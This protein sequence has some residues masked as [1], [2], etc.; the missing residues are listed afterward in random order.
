M[1]KNFLLTLTVIVSCVFN[2]ASQDYETILENIRTDILSNN[3]TSE[4]DIAVASLLLTIQDDGSWTDINYS[5]TANTKWQPLEHLFRINQLS[6]AYIDS[7]STYHQDLNLF[8]VIENALTYWDTSDPQSNNWW[9]NQ[10]ASPRELG[11]V[12]VL[13]RAGSSSISNSLESNLISQMSRGNPEARK[14]A[15]KVDIATHFIYRA[16]LTQN[17]T[18]MNRGVT[19]VFLPIEITNTDEGLQHDYSYRD[20]GPQQAIASYGTVFLSGEVNAA[21]YLLG[22]S[23]ALSQAK[24]DI[25]TQYTLKTI[26]NITRGQHI[27]HSTVGRGISRENTTLGYRLITTLTKLKALDPTNEPQYS[28]EINRLNGS[29]APN[30]MVNEAHTQYWRSDFAVHNRAGYNFSV[31]TSST[32]VKKTEFGNGENRKG[33]Y[34]ADGGSYITIDGDEYYNIYPIW[35]WAKVP[36]ITVPEIT[37]VPQPALW[38]KLGTSTFSGGVSDGLYGIKAHIQNEY[39]TPAKKG[40]FFFDDEV[41]CLGS[42]ISSSATQTIT[43][44]INQCLLDGDV[45]VQNN[46]STTIL[47]PNSNLTYNSTSEWILH[48]NIGYFFPQGGQVKLS[49]HTQSGTWQSINTGESSNTVSKSVFKL[50]IDHGTQPS[51]GSYAYI[52]APNKTSVSQMQAYNTNNNILIT[53]NNN[54]V[55]AVK[56]TGLDMLQIIFYEAGSYD[57]GTTK[58]EVDQPCTLLLKNVSTSSITVHIADPSQQKSSIN[59]FIDI[60]NVTDTRHISNTMPTGVYAGS[61]IVHT[62]DINTPI[63]TVTEEEPLTIITPI[64]DAYVNSGT[65]KNINY[66]DNVGLIVKKDKANTT[67]QSYL[68]F[69]LSSITNSNI[70]SAKL[71]LSI[72]NTNTGVTATSWDA[73]YVNDDSWTEMGITWNNKPLPS[74]LLD[75]QLAVSS[76]YIEWNITPQVLSEMDDDGILSLNISSTVAGSKTDARFWS[77]EY[78]VEAEKP[79]LIIEY[80][81]EEDNTTLKQKKST[82]NNFSI[83]PNPTTSVLNITGFSPIKSIKIL[84]LH[85]KVLQK[86]KPNGVSTNL[87][88]SHYPNGI[89]IISVIDNMDK[90]ITKKIIKQ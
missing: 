80:T 7:G 70:A 20:H 87:N 37:N 48:N 39:N 44:T 86:V 63:K 32:R 42:D 60:P 59:I 11:K 22:T 31:R 82:S 71:R 45:T 40:W 19:Q 16:A 52:V 51:N 64:A 72:A 75:N 81:D 55:Q 90:I 56:H 35:D 36:G 57:D 69:D 53:Q 23:Y 49:T 34:L 68:K 9:Y 27:D 61:S 50:W 67:R 58:I 18:L 83:Y 28:A 88:L 3:N 66:G 41:V 62:A 4:N 12:L 73:K 46:G 33:A 15:N 65:K 77:K 84:D 21:A 8:T 25:L 13:L 30:Y 79:Q 78:T 1:T 29:Q 85:G 76:G 54:A 2:V 17:A 47:P 43:S 6:R 38:G 10:I 24:L 26:I 74:T 5:S 14:A 89:Y